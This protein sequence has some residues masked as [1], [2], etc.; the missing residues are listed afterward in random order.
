MF[1]TAGSLAAE[2]FGVE[3]IG[4]DDD[5]PMVVEIRRDNVTLGVES[6]TARRVEVLPH[7][8]RRLVAVFPQKYALR[9]EQLDSMIARVRH[10][11]L[12]LRVDGDVPRVIKLTAS[13]TFFAKAQQEEPL[14]RQDL[15]HN[16]TFFN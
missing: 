15:K 6:D 5:D 11:D 12:T 3:K 2:N 14:H 13:A 16:S 4:V 1:R 7:T 10:D 9:A 8:R